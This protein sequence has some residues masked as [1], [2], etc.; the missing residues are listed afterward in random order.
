MKARMHLR[1]YTVD[2]LERKCRRGEDGSGVK[3]G[4]CYFSNREEIRSAHLSPVLHSV[5]TP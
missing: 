1:L 2:T 3:A 4:G 5:V